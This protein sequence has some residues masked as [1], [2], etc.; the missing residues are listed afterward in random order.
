MGSSVLGLASVPL[1]WD[2]SGKSA[3]VLF[4][5]VIV[6]LNMKS[7]QLN[8]SYELVLPIFDCLYKP[9]ILTEVTIISHHAHLPAFA[10]LPAAI[11][12][13]P[14]T[15]Y[16]SYLDFYRPNS[17]NT[18]TNLSMVYYV[19]TFELVEKFDEKEEEDMVSSIA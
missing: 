8:T 15:H 18:T 2:A 6:C 1:G 9:H 4:C 10:L 19:N 16:I 5:R 7:R 17:T 3:F 14:C 12:S 13:H 11:D